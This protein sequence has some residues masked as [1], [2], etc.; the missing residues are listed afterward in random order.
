[1]LILA[2]FVAS[3]SGH[4]ARSCEIKHVDQGWIEKFTDESGN[5]FVIPANG[6]TY[7]S[8]MADCKRWINASDIN[9]ER[10]HLIKKKRKKSG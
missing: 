5:A 6:G 4:P 8:A 7:D 1:M 3:F 10:K 2:I 9:S